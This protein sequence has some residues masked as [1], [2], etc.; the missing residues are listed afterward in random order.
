MPS[1][2]VM[3]ALIKQ[4]TVAHQEPRRKAARLVLDLLRST[5]G[6]RDLPRTLETVRAED[7]PEVAA[8][9]HTLIDEYALGGPSD[10]LR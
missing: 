8:E 5:Q 6:F 9:M 4:A 2:V 3:V 1:D 10:L 7:G